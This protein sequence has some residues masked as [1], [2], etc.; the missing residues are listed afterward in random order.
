MGYFN[1]NRSGAFM[2]PARYF[3]TQQNNDDDKEGEEAVVDED[4]TPIQS[5]SDTKEFKAETRKLLDIVAKSIYTDKEVFI[6]ELLSNCSDALE[7]QRFN[8]TS[9]KDQPTDGDEDLGIT[10]TTNSKERTITL[11]DSGVGMT[12]EEIIDNLGTIAKSG[13]KE[14]REAIENDD[15]AVGGAEDSIIGQFGVGFYSSFVVSDHVEVYSKSGKSQTGTRWVSDGC[16]TYEVSDVDNLDFERGTKITLKLLPESREFS[17]DPVVEKIIKKFSQFI[18]YPIKLNG[19]VINSLGAIWSREKRDVTIDEYERFFEQLASTKIPYKYML[20]YSTDVPISIKALLYVPSTHN[21]R[22]GLMQEQQDI[23][24]YSRKVLIKEK[25][26]ELLP[27]YLRFVKGVVDCEDLPLNISRENYQDSGL[28]TKLRNVITR[29]VIKMIDDE[30]KRDPEAYKKWYNDFGQFLKEGIAVDSD[31]KDALFRLIRVNSKNGGAKKLVSLDE[32]IENM[33]E[34]QEKIYYIVN[35]QYELGVKSP[36]MEPFKN[37]KEVDVLILTNNVDEIIFQQSVEYKG[38][39]FVSIE[40]KFD[41]IQKDL[42]LDSE[43][44]SLER[45]RIPEQDITGFCLWLKEELKDSI[46]KVAISKRLK[47]TPAIVSGNMS[48]SMRIMMQMMESQG[49]INDPGMMEKAAKEQ[50]LELNAAHP[51]VVNL[52]QLRKQNKQAAK[53]VSRQFLDN[54]LVQSGIPFDL[55]AGCDRQFRLI[56]SYLELSVNQYAGEATRAVESEEPEVTIETDTAASG[57]SALNQAR[58]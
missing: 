46:G 42:G 31:N 8:F 53:L 26:S 50:V 55:Q 18:A 49:Q 30:A 45:S 1:K 15:E 21:E 37:I 2:Q 58:D 54:V 3:S 34:G 9:G 12:R 28:I 48:S 39:K 40:S 14:F 43:M 24:L 13:S 7:K 32:Y 56:D 17:Q 51:I 41:E 6:R 38:K 35:N 44:E 57:K 52:N 20:H 47:D 33:K 27:H 5:N 19:A 23:H 36:Y 4:R 11:F 25:C 10:I 16:G 29:R 22:Q